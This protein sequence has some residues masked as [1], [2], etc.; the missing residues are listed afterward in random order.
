MFDQETLS[1]EKINPLDYTPNQFANA[2]RDKVEKMGTSIV[3]LDSISGYQLSFQ[4]TTNE[5]A[6]DD[7]MLRH[8]HILAE[9]LK[10]LGVSLIL[11]N[12]IHDI[13]GD[14]KVSEH[15]ISYIADNIIFIRYIEVKGEI[16]RAIGVLKKRLSGF[17][18]TLREFDIS[19][20]GIEVG[21]PLN[22]LRGVLSG[23]P[24]FIQPNED[25]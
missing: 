6:K 8:I 15:G 3:V 7:E 4:G 13:T 23:V 16:R 9:H 18:K 10:S 1:I 19:S 5:R 21:D 11:I 14:F 24:E 17:E 22:K 12:E 25:G 2:V 20:N